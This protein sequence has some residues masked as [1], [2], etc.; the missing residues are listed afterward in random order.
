MKIALISTARINKTSILE[1]LKYLDGFSVEAIFSRN[2]VTARNY[3][4]QHNINVWGSHEEIK[5]FQESFDT[6]Y[7]SVPNALHYEFSKMLLE[8][9]KNVVCEKP[10]CFSQEEAQ[11]LEGIARERKR[12]ILEAYHFKYHPDSIKKIRSINDLIVK[13]NTQL[14]IFIGNVLPASN[15]IR[16]NKSL[17]GGALAHLGCYISELLT[18]LN[19]ELDV[20]T[21]KINKIKKKQGVD[22]FVEA[23]LDLKNSNK[24]NFICDLDHSHLESYAVIDVMN[25]TYIFNDIFTPSSRSTYATNGAQ[26]SSYFYQLENFKDFK[27]FNSISGQ[28]NLKGIQ[29]FETMARKI[30]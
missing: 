4:K 16:L 8:L 17:G 19:A 25:H 20:S 18:S 9:D 24:V 13:P 5:K 22:T 3:A 21:L 11:A 15:D 30:A 28:L 2:K 23:S 10:L 26:H 29:L 27:N 1:P 14:R 7:I 6:A 12:F